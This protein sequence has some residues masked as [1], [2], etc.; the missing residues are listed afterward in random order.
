[1]RGENQNGFT[2]IETTIFMAVSALLFVTV[3]VGTGTAISR[4]RYT[5]SVRTTES[6][7]QQKVDQTFS[8]SNVRDGSQVCSAGLISAAGGTPQYAGTSNCYV[9]GKA[10]RMHS[11]NSSQMNVYNV[12]G[13]EPPSLITNGLFSDTSS[14]TDVVKAWNPRA[15]MS[16]GDEDY[17]IPWDAFVSGAGA[18]QGGVAA[19]QINT[20]LFLRSPRSGGLL[21]YTTEVG[22][23]ASV[24]GNGTFPLTGDID[25]ADLQRSAQICLQSREF[26]INAVVAAIQLT[27]QGGQSAIEAKFDGVDTSKC[28]TIP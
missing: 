14:E 6:F 5:D 18:D 11:G 9:L 2:I 13:T 28:R 12:I 25:Q 20:L 23:P 19:Q 3:L 7:L 8:F 26:Q 22:W 17:D 24:P 4:Q 21:V 16:V 1:M 27:G 15:V 10:V